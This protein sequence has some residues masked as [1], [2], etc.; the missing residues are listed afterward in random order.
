MIRRNCVEL[1]GES[2]N[3]YIASVSH[4]VNQMGPELCAEGHAWKAKS[5]DDYDRVKVEIETKSG[6]KLTAYLEYDGNGWATSIF[7][8]QLKTTIYREVP[9]DGF[10]E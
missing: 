2:D 5:G 9:V 6:D 10:H 7:G 4:F 1:T 3:L 8:D